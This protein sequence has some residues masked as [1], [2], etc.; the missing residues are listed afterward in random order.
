MAVPMKVSTTR[1]ALRVYDGE[2][3]RGDASPLQI[4]PHRAVLMPVS[5][6]KPRSAYQSRLLSWFVVAFLAMAVGMRA[7][8]FRLSQALIPVCREMSET[9][10]LHGTAG[11]P[12]AA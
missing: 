2:A 11:L 5:E 3:W 8:S 12:C 9:K 4:Q 7:P 6:A 10:A 1:E